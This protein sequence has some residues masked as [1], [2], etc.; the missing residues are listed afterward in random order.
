MKTIVCVLKSGGEY[1]AQYVHKLK[2]GIDKNI[3][4]P[5][6]FVCLTDLP[7]IEGIET[8]QLEFTWQ[9]WWAKMELFKPS[10]RDLGDFL[11]IDLDTVIVDSLDVLFKRFQ[12]SA[13]RDMYAKE[14][15]KDWSGRVGSGVMRLTTALRHEIWADWIKKPTHNIKACGVYGDQK[16][17]KDFF[18]P[19]PRLQDLFP[20]FFV[21]YKAGNVKDNGVPKD[22]GMIVFHGLPRPKEVDWL[23]D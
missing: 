8:R 6:R 10:M 18:I 14:G 13:L 11:Y 20:K 15:H 12:N 22:A 19:L 1:D 9:G 16:Y 2:E 3:K 7:E 17:L 4:K 5:Y 21:S 23:N